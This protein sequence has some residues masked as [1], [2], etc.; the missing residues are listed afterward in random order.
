MPSLSRVIKMNEN[1]III[2]AGGHGAAVA[3]IVRLCNDTVVGFLDD[4]PHKKGVLGAA[5][6][7][8]KYPDCRFIIALG[9]ADLRERFMAEPMRFYT[10]VHPHACVS[11]C[12]EIGEGSAVM[13][14]TVINC[15][16][17]IG[18]GAIINTLSGVDHDCTV[19][20][21]CHV[22]PG[23]HL[24]GTVSVGR[25]CMIGTGASVINNINICDGVT[26]G[27]GAA[28]IRDITEPGVYAGVPAKKIKGIF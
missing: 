28:V 12:A 27:A 19:G 25:A 10:A 7:W 22:C 14:G 9:D 3:E 6:E 26:V 17:R 4:D 23:A 1:V 15:G 21:F 18:K 24:A 8:R 11:P 5:D 13:A 20:D 2:G 16:A